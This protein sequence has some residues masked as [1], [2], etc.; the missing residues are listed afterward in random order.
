MDQETILKTI[1][2]VAI[3]AAGFLWFAIR[4]SWSAAKRDA[5]IDGLGK[6]LDS[7][8]ERVDDHDD[9]GERLARVEQGFHDVKN[10][11]HQILTAV[12]KRPAE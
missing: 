5:V 11:L 1:G 10:Y 12:N 7:L 3:P 2:A 8:K 4:M 9:L 6:S